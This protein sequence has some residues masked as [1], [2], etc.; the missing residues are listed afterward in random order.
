MMTSVILPIHLN[1]Y[2]VYIIYLNQSSHDQTCSFSRQKLHVWLES[3]CEPSWFYTIYVQSSTQTHW[4][5]VLHTRLHPTR[6][7]HFSAKPHRRN[8][9]NGKVRPFDHEDMVLFSRSLFVHPNHLT[10]ALLPSQFGWLLHGK[11]IKLVVE[12][13]GI[14]FCQRQWF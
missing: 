3:Q 4:N 5:E 12:A 14:N 2:L 6:Q 10:L 11:W 1:R 8:P 9:D 13:S 7:N